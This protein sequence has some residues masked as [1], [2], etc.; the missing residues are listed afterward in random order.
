MSWVLIVRNCAKI[1]D[2]R[3][4]TT[5]LGLW[6]KA[7]FG[8]QEGKQWMV[9]T[10]TAKDQRRTAKLLEKQDERG[11]TVTLKWLANQH[12]ADTRRSYYRA[13]RSSRSC[14]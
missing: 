13:L 1:V 7:K 3:E 4:S 9:L 8:R 5:Q 11:A 2:Q 14:D 6:N 10:F 12:K